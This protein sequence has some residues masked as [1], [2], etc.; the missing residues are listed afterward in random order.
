MYYAFREISLTLFLAGK[1][2]GLE[3][4]TEKTKYIFISHNQNI[5]G[6]IIL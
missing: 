2:V 6:K 5:E 3:G 1:G 4:N